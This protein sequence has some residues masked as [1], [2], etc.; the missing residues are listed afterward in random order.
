MTALMLAAFKANYVMVNT[1]L[2]N[3][4]EVNAQNRFNG[5]TALMYAAIRPTNHS[6]RADT[7]DIIQVLMEYGADPMVKN[8]TGRT[9]FDLATDRQNELFLE[10][11]NQ[12]IETQSQPS[13]SKRSSSRPGRV[14]GS[15]IRFQY[16][17]LAI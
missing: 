10:T 15:L 1:L 11:V 16:F 12:F 3:G 6:S 5:W 8:H 14:T 9:C 7:E 17:P 4:A 2:S 13:S